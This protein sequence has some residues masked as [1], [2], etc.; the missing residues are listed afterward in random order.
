MQE[1]LNEKVREV[2]Q[3]ESFM[4]SSAGKNDDDGPHMVS[5]AVRL[6]E[7]KFSGARPLLPFFSCPR[8][9]SNFS[10]AN[11][12]DPGYLN[13]RFEESDVLPSIAVAL[14]AHSIEDALKGIFTAFPPRDSVMTDPTPESER[15]LLTSSMLIIDGVMIHQFL[16]GYGSNLTWLD[17]SSL[18]RNAKL[19]I[20]T[21]ETLASSKVIG[22]FGSLLQPTILFQHNNIIGI[23]SPLSKEFSILSKCADFFEAGVEYSTYDLISPVTAE[24][25]ATVTTPPSATMDDVQFTPLNN[26]INLPSN[27]SLFPFPNKASQV[28]QAPNRPAE[29]PSF[30]SPSFADHLRPSTTTTVHDPRVRTVNFPLQLNSPTRSQSYPSTPSPFRSGALSSSYS[31]MSRSQTSSLSARRSSDSPPPNITPVTSQEL[32][33][34]IADGLDILLI[35]I[36]AFAAYAKSRLTDAINV[37]IP[38]VLLKRSSLSMSDISGSIVSKG[39]RGRFGGWKEADG[40]VLYDADSLRVKDSHPLATL[41]G[42][43]KEAGFEGTTYGLIGIPFPRID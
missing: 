42:K 29:S 7:D 28:S 9:Y 11:D 4:A 21:H 43:F 34:L 16:R 3:G 26:Y 41:A 18:Q 10:Q 36:R 23:Y 37:C 20:D 35:D 1:R 30:F 12:G 13:E 27:V 38:T 39:D 33:K 25:S 15:N 17:D 31:S 40:I 5:A 32:E 24:P 22:A 19:E 8:K 14:K 6:P 2:W